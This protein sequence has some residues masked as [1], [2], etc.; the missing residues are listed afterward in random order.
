VL[1]T[2]NFV[3][4]GS[5]G[6]VCPTLTPTP[7]QQTAPAGAT[8]NPSAVVL[9]TVISSTSGTASK[10]AT[11]GKGKGKGKTGKNE[12][13]DEYD[14]NLLARLIAQLIDFIRSLFGGGGGFLGGHDC[15][16]GE[17]APIGTPVPT[18][19]AS[20]ALSSV[21]P[22]ALVSSPTVITPTVLITAPAVIPSTSPI[23]TATLAPTATPVPT[24]TP[25]PT[26]TPVPSPTPIPTVFPVQAG[27]SNWGGYA[28]H[29]P[30]GLT[31]ATLRANWTVS[32][33][34]C[35]NALNMSPWIGFGGYEPSDGDIA[36]LGIDFQ[37]NN[38]QAG[39]FPWTEAFPANPI[40]Y[41]DPI[42]VGDQISENITYKGNGSY[43]T[44]MMD[45][46]KGWSI[47]LPMSFPGVNPQTGEIIVELLVGPITPYTPVTFSN[48]FYSNNGQP[49]QPVVAAP[50]IVRTELEYNKIQ[51]TQTSPLTVSGFSIS[52]K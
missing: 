47:S 7:G 15:N 19:T 22:I 10:S 11:K 20:A 49:E 18:A 4:V 16:P 27:L 36:Q 40:Y 9:P 8:V 23:P 39:F 29:V 45:T 28:Y 52:K 12:N 2:Q 37:C 35:T 5:S 17:T 31:A 25:I 50:G 38:G 34:T 48:I 41:K 26:A 24:A 43:M 3:C 44:N 6:G 1:P 30:T 33:V 46:T 13:C 21:T 51:Q 14:G 32:Q 42:S